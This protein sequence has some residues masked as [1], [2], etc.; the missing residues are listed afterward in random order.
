MEEIEEPLDTYAKVSMHIA[1]MYAYLVKS[2]NAQRRGIYDL[3]I[4]RRHGKSGH[5]TISSL[6]FLEMH[7]MKIIFF[8][9]IFA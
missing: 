3:E 8:S 5:F 2:Y 7:N 1:C 9:T 6:F 4:I